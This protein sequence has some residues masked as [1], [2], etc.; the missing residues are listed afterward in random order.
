MDIRSFQSADEGAIV[1]LWRQCGLLRPWNDPYKDI[2]RNLLV[3]S[4]WFLVGVVGD[5]VIATVM[6]GFDGHR[7]WI[8]Y[9]AV[10]P[11]RQRHGHGKAMME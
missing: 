8:N 3:Q 7:G 6:V 2:A 4:E 10:D 5:Q 1:E 9:L 11:S